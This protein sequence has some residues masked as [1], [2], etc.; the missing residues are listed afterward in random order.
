MVVHDVWRVRRA[1]PGRHRARRPHHRHAALRHVDRVGVPVGARGA[2]QEPREQGQP[3]GHGRAG[4]AGLGQG[5]ALPR[6]GARPGRGVGDR[7][8]V[9]VLGRLRRRLRGPREEDDARGGRTARHRGGVVRGARRRRDLHRRLGTA[10]R[11]RAA[12]PDAGGAERRDVR[13][14]RCHQGRRDLCALLQHDQER[15]PADR[16]ELRGRAPHPAAQ[17]PGARQEARAGG[18]AGGR[19]G[20]VDGAQR[21]LHC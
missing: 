19:A 6:Q 21:C 11:Q 17:P 20:D 2:V 7:R 16:R 3:V 1:V 5:P 8:R 10:G 15:V 14:V 18:A 12:V 4:P 13:G 9:A